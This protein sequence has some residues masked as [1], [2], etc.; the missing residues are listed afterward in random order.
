VKSDIRL[1]KL[2]SGPIG[3]ILLC[4][5]R[6]VQSSVARRAVECG[7]E[8]PAFKAAALLPQ[9]K[10][11]AGFGAQPVQPFGHSAFKQESCLKLP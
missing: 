1:Q 5:L 4:T 9:S 8:A 7:S 6:R 2:E 11:A 3:L 10:V